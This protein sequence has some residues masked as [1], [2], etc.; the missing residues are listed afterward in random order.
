MAKK[1]AT[2][3]VNNMPEEFGSGIAVGKVS[4][5][6]F[7]AFEKVNHVHRDNYHVF[8]L[9]E[10]GSARMEVD[11]EEYIM[12]QR[13]LG[14][15]HPHQVHRIISFE[16]AAFI[17]LMVNSEN[18]NPKYLELLSQI[19][20][21]KPLPLTDGAFELINEAA[22]LCVK[23]SEQKDD[24]LYNSL[25]KDS[26]N[27][28]IGLLTSQYTKEHESAGRHSRFE[29]VT[30]KFKNLLEHNFVTQKRPAQ[31]A[32]TLSISTAYL[33]ECVKNTTGLPVSH[34]IQ[35]RVILEAKRLLFHSAKSVK[36]IATELGYDDYAYFSR[37][38]TKATGTTAQAFRAKNRD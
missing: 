4:F 38:F 26:C 22:T 36:E 12:Q 17:A 25:L 35:Q 13:S 2:I 27:T 29:V 15:I 33:N 19:G 23:L 9:L 5:E 14:Y 10:S 20:F 21:A 16:N 37:L 11:F 6:N 34:H 7:D 1:T 30:K 18:L 8:F 32:E 24:K 28:F 3:P 31:Y